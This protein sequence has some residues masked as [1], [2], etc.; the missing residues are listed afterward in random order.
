MKKQL[1]M[2]WDLAQPEYALETF[3][4]FALISQKNTLQKTLF[5]FSLEAIAYRTVCQFLPY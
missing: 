1:S 3:F 5:L 2:L 4:M